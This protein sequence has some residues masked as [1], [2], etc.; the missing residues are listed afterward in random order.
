[1]QPRWTPRFLLFLSLAFTIGPCFASLTMAADDSSSPQNAGNHRLKLAFVTC[2]VDQAFFG[3]VKKGMRDA[4]KMM[5]VDCNFIGTKEVDLP[6]QA[7][8]VRQ[9]LA[10]G[11]DGIAVNLIDANAFDEV[12]ADAIAK[13]VPVV[14]FNVDDSAS[15]NA[16]L[17]SVNQRLYEAGRSVGEHAL[18]NVPEGAHVLMT[19]HDEGVSALEDRLRGIQ[20]VLKK[21]NVTWT[22]VVTGN[23]AQAGVDA[24]AKALHDHP[25][26]RIIFGSGQSDTEAAGRAIEAHFAN[27]GYWAAGFDL[28]PKTLQLVQDGHIRF[29]IDQQPYVQGFYPVVEL[30]LKLRYGIAPSDI[31]AGAGVVDQSNVKQIMRW[32]AE[33]YR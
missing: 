28:S 33:G 5:D 9:A 25:D 3:P 32:T 4:A 1:M 8:M 21:K 26:I 24:I 11:Y 19:K 29:T 23:D 17:A 6:E 18:T 27:Q 31:D 14:A 2:C 7:K 20:D 16:R 12:V 10:D 15:P 13:G 30:T 22:T